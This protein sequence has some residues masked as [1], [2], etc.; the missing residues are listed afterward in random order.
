MSVSTS[1]AASP[2][3]STDWEDWFDSRIGGDFYSF[4]RK[5]WNY[6]RRL[7]EQLCRIL[8][9]GGRVL[10]CG[11]GTG[12]YSSYLSHFGFDVT[13]IDL[14]DKML[15]MA[16]AYAEKLRS[17]STFEHGDL[18]DLSRYYGRFDVTYSIGVLEHFV[19]PD[20]IKILTE[21]SKCAPWLLISI[22]SR[23]VWKR[24]HE[25]FDGLML[26][27]TPSSLRSL[28]Q[29]AGYE[30]ETEFSHSAANRIGRALE[31]GTPE[32]IRKRIFPP[33]AASIGV[34]ARSPRFKPAT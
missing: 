8:P 2:S 23:H 16:R 26:P 30:I 15:Q 9:T 34:V 13:G 4:A 31:L 28:V 7:F 17:A 18:Y 29:G 3:Q 11:C 10:E 1:E 20:A 12:I 25:S 22:P 33:F 6:N 27:H 5:R 21:Q 14:D 24:E 32:I 19:E